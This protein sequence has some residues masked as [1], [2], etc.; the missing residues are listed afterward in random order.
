M[1]VQPKVK[2]TTGRKALLQNAGAIVLG[3]KDNERHKLEGVERIKWKRQ[4][5]QRL[6]GQIESCK[7]TMCLGRGRL[8]RRSSGT[9]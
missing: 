6:C 7:I 5:S 3:V 2:L 9:G 1:P 8:D 4:I